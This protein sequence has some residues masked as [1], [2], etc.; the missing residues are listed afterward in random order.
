MER[1]N[2]RAWNHYIVNANRE[3]HRLKSLHCKLG[4]FSNTSPIFFLKRVNNSYNTL[5]GG[6]NE[7]KDNQNWMCKIR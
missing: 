5:K 6:K 2:I 3:L 4:M 7:E 1:R